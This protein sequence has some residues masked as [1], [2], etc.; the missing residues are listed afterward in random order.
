MKN[1]LLLIAAFSLTLFGEDEKLILNGKITLQ[2]GYVITQEAGLDSI[3]G[4]ISKENGLNIKYD[5]GW[6]SGNYLRDHSTDSG[7]YEFYYE[8][9]LNDK[10]V[11]IGMKKPN[12]LYVVFRENKKWV[13]FKAVV[14]D[15]KDIAEMLT[16]TLSYVS[17]K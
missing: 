2:P 7:K 11:Y 17:G 13:N 12:V 3:P 16:I 9:K 4:V 14:K 10:D 8:T 15:Q 6:M 5:I 1:A